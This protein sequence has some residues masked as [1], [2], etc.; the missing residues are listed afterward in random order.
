MFKKLLL[1]SFLFSL[2]G[3]IYP[4]KKENTKLFDFCHSFEKILSRNAVKKSIN[5]SEKVKS[6]SEYITK[7]GIKKT[8]GALINKM[9]SKYKTSKNSPIINLV[10]NQIYCFAGYWIE[11]IS[12]G[13]LES[14]LYS[15]SKKSINEF[16][17]MKKELDVKLKDINAEYKV[18][19]KEFNSLF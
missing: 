14:I 7:F 8:R 5:V 18:I 4:T 16:K 1:I 17:D 12:P 9:I 6:N 3:V 10:P 2:V 13:T 15:R 11:M 19:K